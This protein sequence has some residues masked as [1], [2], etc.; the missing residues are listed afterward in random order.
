MRRRCL[1][2]TLVAAVL[3]LAGCGSSSS[4]TSISSS[5]ASS[6]NP[7]GSSS[8]VPDLTV[9][10]AASLK[11][12]FTAYGAK[13]ALAHARFSFAGSDILAAQIEQGVKPD[14][15]A[16]ANTTLPEKL[17]AK[18]LVEQPVTF[19]ANKLVLAVPASSKI[20]SIAD[21]E[22]SGTTI[23]IGSAT[24]PIGI[25]TRKVLAK[26]GPAQSQ[27]ILGNVRSAEP[28][29][30][31]IVGKLTEGAVDAGFTYVTDVRATHGKLKA[32][33]LPASL[34]PV[35]AYDVAVVK[36]TGHPVQAEQFIT[37]LLHGEGS[38]ALLAAGFLA[39][40]RT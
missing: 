4:S 1:V 2:L 6:A 27:Q 32:I 40:P 19:A 5:T 31:G 30:S 26:L 8:R 11:G 23:A 3:A 17:Y 12:A 38:A 37:G 18:G 15:F 10:A 21:A 24:V 22:K 16:S 36:G 28:D 25:Y 33:E 39:P 20:T 34:Q 13:F 35:V 7:S 29:V 9:S 14:V